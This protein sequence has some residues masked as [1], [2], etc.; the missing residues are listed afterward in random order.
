MWV[1]AHKYQKFRRAFVDG[2]VHSFFFVLRQESF[3]FV[4]AIVIVTSN[5]FVMVEQVQSVNFH[6]TTL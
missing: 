2:P 6:F 5:N 1:V 3:M 4:V